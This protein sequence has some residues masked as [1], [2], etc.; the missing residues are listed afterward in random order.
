MKKQKSS[1]KNYEQLGKMLV[2]IYESGYLDK[3]Q[4][5]KQSFIKG[6]L[7]GVGGVLGAT[8]VIALLLWVLSLFKNV[9]PLKPFVERTTETIQ[10]R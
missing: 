4:T 9:D 6:V 5:Y 2:S 10:Q 7:G 1:T 3:K 8:I